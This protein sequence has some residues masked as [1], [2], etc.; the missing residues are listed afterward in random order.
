MNL[1]KYK[2][3]IFDLFH[4]LTS[5]ES[6]RAPGKGTSAILGVTRKDWNDQLLKYS[7]D[8]LRGIIKN[9]YKIIKKMAHAINPDIPEDIIKEATD[10]RMARFKYS[11]QHIDPSVLDTLAKLRDMGK[12]IGL[13]SNGDVHEIAGWDESPLYKYF[14][15]VI[16]SCNVGYIKPER[17]IYEKSLED[18]K[19]NP[20][21]CLF[22][23]D[24]GS[25]EL[26]G[27]KEI[28]M[29]TVLITYIIEKIWPEKLNSRRKYADFELS[30]INEIII[31]NK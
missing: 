23:G 7:Q 15:S 4:T 14:N 8:R 18:L 12:L 1:S 27:A 3:V 31:N 19:V 22:I 30:E 11:L 13:I 29:N 17:E 10:T 6:A 5:V 9:P 2:A 16:F 28:G 20:E 26:Q 24:G 25:D 21:E